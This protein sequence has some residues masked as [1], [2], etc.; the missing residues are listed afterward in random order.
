M[1]KKLFKHELSDLLKYI[2]FAWLGLLGVSILASIS[3]YNI[4]HYQYG[5]YSDPFLNSEFMQMQLSLFTQGSMSLFVLAIATVWILTLVMI[6]VRFY[7]SMLSN[8]GYLTHSL[9]FKTTQLLNAKLL[10]GVLALLLDVCVILAASAIVILPTALSEGGIQDIIEA[11]GDLFEFLFGSIAP[12]YAVIMSVEAV[13]IGILVLF[14]QIL[15][16]V[17]CMSIGQRFK[18]RVLASV[19]IYIGGQWAVQFISTFFTFFISTFIFTYE[20]V[21]FG[22]MNVDV[23]TVIGETIVIAVLAGACAV[24][25][26][27]SRH[28]LTKKLNLA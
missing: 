5:N 19:L 4:S 20:D 13:I 11:F 24:C 23:E 18:N 6:I 15:Y 22:T 14:L 8:E 25:Y 21:I 2:R 26:F 10:C 3:L 12:G 28:M 16:P 17:L 7:R 1:V 9:P 27:I